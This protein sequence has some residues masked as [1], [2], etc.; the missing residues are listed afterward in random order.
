MA[1]IRSWKPR[2]IAAEVARAV[3]GWEKASGHAAVWVE[4]SD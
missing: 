3:R 1:S 2:L 4:I